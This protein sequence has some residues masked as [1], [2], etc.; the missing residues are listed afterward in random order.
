MNNCITEGFGRKF[1]VTLLYEPGL[2]SY[3]TFV[4]DDTN[5][6]V[7]LCSQSIKNQFYAIKNIKMRDLNE[8]DRKEDKYGNVN[9]KDMMNTLCIYGHNEDVDNEF[10]SRLDEELNYKFYSNFEK[11]FDNVELFGAFESIDQMSKLIKNIFNNMTQAT[12]NNRV[13][14]YLESKVKDDDGNIRTLSDLIASSYIKPDIV[15][16]MNVV[17]YIYK[18]FPKKL[19]SNI[20]TKDLS[21]HE[22]L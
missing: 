1:E 10:N 5:N 15:D 4:N 13:R 18:R 17:E 9:D 2:A 6:T 22:L 8:N 3:K 21:K 11:K 16:S 12:Y 20:Y 14:I 19:I 7:F